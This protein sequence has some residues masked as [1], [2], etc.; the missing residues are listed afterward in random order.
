MKLSYKKIY[1]KVASTENNN[2][3]EVNGQV[4][5]YQCSQG[6]ISSCHFSE[7]RSVTVSHALSAMAVDGKLQLASNN[8]D[9]LAKEGNNSKPLSNSLACHNL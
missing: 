1:N 3:V 8:H 9:L 7:A 6:Q 4:Q 5:S 2:F